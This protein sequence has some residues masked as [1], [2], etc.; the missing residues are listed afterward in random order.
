[1]FQESIRPPG[2]PIGVYGPAA[3]DMWLA[4]AEGDTSGM[5]LSS[6]ARNV[7]LPNFFT[8]GHLLAMGGSSGEYAD[9]TRDYRAEFDPPESIL[10]SPMSLLAW[11]MGKGWPTKLIPEE[12]LEL[13][14]TDVE[15]LLE[16]GSIDFSTPPQG[17]DELLPYLRN[18]EQ[19]ILEEF[20]HG[21]TFWNSQP[22]A[23]V[24]LLN[25]FFDSGEVDSS[26]YVYQPLEFDVGRGWPGLAKLLLGIVLVLFI[27][28]AVFGWFTVRT[29][30][31]R[32][33][34]SAKGNQEFT[35]GESA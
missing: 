19:V 9:P 8:W 28:L 29:I 12:Y 25:T 3:V 1:M 26:I 11:S 6:L 4:A 22:E 30:R 2:D 10:G 34:R 5:A 13:Q 35:R 24:H 27:L 18:G 15:T 23:R 16:S 7:F 33:A 17:A 14:P 31:Q 32:R 21:N 20:G